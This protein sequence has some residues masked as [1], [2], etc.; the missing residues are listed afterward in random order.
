MGIP[1]MATDGRISVIS[2]ALKQMVQI[3]IVKCFTKSLLKKNYGL[4]YSCHLSVETLIFEDNS[5]NVV[6]K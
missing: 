2:S 4:N 6:S 1:Q 3:F 5:M